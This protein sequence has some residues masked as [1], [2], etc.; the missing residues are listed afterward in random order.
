ML[1]S[2]GRLAGRASGRVEAGGPG[3]GGGRSREV[4]GEAPT[5]RAGQGSSPQPRYPIPPVPHSLVNKRGSAPAGFGNDLPTFLTKVDRQLPLCPSPKQG[6]LRA[7]LQ[8]MMWDQGPW[9]PEAC[10]R[11]GPTHPKL[12]RR[13]DGRGWLPLAPRLPTQ[14]PALIPQSHLERVPGVERLLQ[15]GTRDAGRWPLTWGY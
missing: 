7:S 9:F 10:P 15:A 13:G 6:R 14:A 4:P 12:P 5:P 1:V 8:E 3:A 11:P 2:V